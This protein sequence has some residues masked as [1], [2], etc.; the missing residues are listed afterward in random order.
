ME[1]QYS[2]HLLLFK[3]HS[4]LQGRATVIG[5]VFRFHGTDDHPRNRTLTRYNWEGFQCVVKSEAK[6]EDYMLGLCTMHIQ[7]ATEKQTGFGTNPSVGLKHLLIK[8]HVLI[9]YL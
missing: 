7:L 3:G 4:L 6:A 8:F 1:K 2:L 5:A 9:S